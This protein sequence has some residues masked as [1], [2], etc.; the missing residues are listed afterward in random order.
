MG[1]LEADTLTRKHGAA[2]WAGG[3]FAVAVFVAV[4]GFVARTGAGR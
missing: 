1:R 4:V 2:G 3:L